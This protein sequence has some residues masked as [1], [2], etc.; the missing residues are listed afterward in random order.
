MD[1]TVLAAQARTDLG[2]PAWWVEPPGYPTSLALAVIDSIQSLG[3]TYRSVENVIDRYREH[4]RSAGDDPDIDTSADLVNSFTEVG[5]TH[6]WAATIGNLNRTSTAGGPLKAVAILQ[7]AQLLVENGLLTGPDVLKDLDRADSTIKSQWLEIPG[8][9]YG[10]S[11][12]YLLI[13]LG[14]EK[15]KPDRMIRGWL[16]RRLGDEGSQLSADQAADVVDALAAHMGVSVRLLD[17]AIWQFER[18]ARAD[19]S[20]S[21]RTIH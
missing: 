15:V 11:W 6:A 12:A 7:A 18:D 17:H 9:R 8:Q 16:A 2:D 5:G 13:L 1:F 10:T 14:A 21:A 20:I 4:R 19:Q 3:V